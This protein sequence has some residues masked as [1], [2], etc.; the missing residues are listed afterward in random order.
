MAEQ[1]ISELEDMTIETSKTEKQREKRLK[2]KTRISKN[3]SITTKGV[4]GVMGTL[5]KKGTEAIF[6]AIM[7]ENF[8]KLK[9]YAGP[10]N[11]ENTRISR[12]NTHHLGIS[13]RHII[14]KLQKNQKEKN[15]ETRGRKASYL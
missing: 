12:I 8:S 3:C 15:L 6:E 13:F 9:S 7:M 5:E 1:R 11:V 4:T 10:G 2:T 14:F